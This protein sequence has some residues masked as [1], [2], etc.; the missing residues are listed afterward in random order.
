MVVASPEFSHKGFAI[1]QLLADVC[2][3]REVYK[4]PPT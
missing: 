4:V 1:A 2:G 3:L